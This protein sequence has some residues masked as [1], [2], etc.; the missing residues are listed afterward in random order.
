MSAIGDLVATLGIDR[1][2]WESGLSGAR[3]SLARFNSSVS[4]AMGKVSGAFGALGRLPVI[5]GVLAGAFGL[6]KSVQMAT[7]AEQA[8]KKLSAVLRATGNAAGFTSEELRQYAADLQ[9]VTNFEDDATVS[10]MAVLATFTQIKGSAFKDAV[11]AAQDLSAVMGQD[12]QSSIVQIGKA[13]NDP[14]KG[15][16]A[17][18]RVGVSFTAEQKKQIQNLVQ[19]GKLFEAQQMILSELRTEFGGAAQAMAD[20]MAQMQNVLGDLGEKLG[21]LVK[22]AVVAFL[23]MVLTG[24]ENISAWFGQF[25]TE[26]SA[27]WGAY[28][29][30]LSALGEAVGGALS[31]LGELIGGGET[32]GAVFKKVLG[33]VTAY[34]QTLAFTVRNFGALAKLVPIE[35][36]LAFLEKFP[37]LEG[38]IQAVAKF[39][40][41]SWAFAKA[42]VSAQINNIIQGFLMLYNVA[43]GVFKGIVAAAQEMIAGNF[44]GMGAA[45][46]AAFREEF[47]KAKQ[48]ARNLKNPFSEGMSAAKQAGDA[49]QQ[50][51]DRSGG[52]TN[53]LQQ[54]RDALNQQIA[55]NEAAYRARKTAQDRDQATGGRGGGGG[56]GALG[57]PAGATPKEAAKAL[58]YGTAE[59]WKSITSAMYG[60]GDDK[61]KANLED[62]GNRQVQI[63]ERIED[64]LGEE[65]AI[66]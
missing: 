41:S 50:R 5:G 66:P 65:V 59:A 16:T 36:A 40:I 60:T 9:K 12:L 62:I 43:A 54:Q 29:E 20:P 8:E 39:F 18:Q 61:H 64:N 34:Y 37:M 1:R 57:H 6:A 4:G 11:A 56:P 31:S 17:L 10:A 46:G 45:F 47:E 53:S 35:I 15:V 3:A 38:P 55:A 13:L 19:Q 26:I 52:L 2:P 32:F 49:F 27:A 23:Q 24:I 58:E 33:W 22:P 14:I 42:F 48:N 44:S 51:M 63:L 7:E 25:S 28:T 21:A 30:Y